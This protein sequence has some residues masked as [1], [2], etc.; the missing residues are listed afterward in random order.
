MFYVGLDIHDKRIAICILSETGQVVRRA[1]VRTIDEMMRI[2]EALPDRFEVSYVA[3]CGYGYYHD[4][5]CPITARVTVAH[6]GRLRLILR[7][8]DNNERK[9]AERLAKLLLVSTA[10][11]VR[12]AQDQSG[13]GCPGRDR[14]RDSGRIPRSDVAHCDAA[15][16]NGSD[17][18][19]S[20]GAPPWR[21]TPNRCLGNPAIV[22]LRS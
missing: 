3:S 19:L 9:D 20:H 12:R 1:Q 4:L 22:S 5:L 18:I 15:V 10:T 7:S 13:G 21:M 2:L 16:L 6:P 14:E 8:K 11:P 17:R